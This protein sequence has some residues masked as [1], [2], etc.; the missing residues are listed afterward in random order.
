M[1][2]VL[3]L[4]FVLLLV[5]PAVGW[6]EQKPSYITFYRHGNEN[7]NRIAI[8]I[9]DWAKPEE[10]LPQFLDVAKENGA[11]LT[12]YPV[13]KYILAKDRALWQRAI[14][15]GHEIGNHSNTHPN[16]ANASR[17]RIIAQLTKMEKRLVDALG[18]DYTINTVRLPY[19]SGWEKGS[20]SAFARAIHDAGYVHVIRW[21]VDTKDLTVSQIMRK[22][23]NGSIV[24]LHAKKGDLKKMTA[25]LPLLKEK[26]FEMVTV[27]QLLGLTKTGRTADAQ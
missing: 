27:S 24:L 23:K 4:F 3:S 21:N 15:E 1:K 17:D 6:A 18:H 19:G 10:W 22:V 5:F 8:T 13:G 7:E 14:D 16:L 25:L 2:R 12:L 9:D 26:G 11:L 20:R